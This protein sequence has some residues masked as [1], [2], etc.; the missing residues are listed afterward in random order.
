MLNQELY[1]F[2]SVV[3]KYIME[4]FEVEFEVVVK[5]STTFIFHQKLQQ[6]IVFIQLIGCLWKNTT[7]ELATLSGNITVKK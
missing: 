1:L 5:F 3:V 4:S 7:L 6:K 2:F